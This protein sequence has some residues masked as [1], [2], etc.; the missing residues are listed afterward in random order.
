MS[1][2]EPAKILCVDDEVKV[3]SGLERTLF[4]HFD[5]HTANSGRAALERMS[6][7]GPFSVIVSDMRMPEMDGAAFLAEAKKRAPDSVRILLTGH[8]D[9]QAAIDAVN[10]GSIYRFLSKPCEPTVLIDTLQQAVKQHRLAS[11]EK[12]LLANTLAAAVKSMVRLLEMV[13]PTAFRK[14]TAM[15]DY[16]HHVC[17]ILKLED[18][19]MYET[20]ALL[21][22]AGHIVLP[23]S[24]LDKADAR[25]ELTAQEKEMVSQAFATAA[26]LAREIPRLEPVGEIISALGQPAKK[27]RSLDERVTLGVRLLDAADRLDVLLRSGVALSQ[28]V[29]E[30]RNLPQE[31]RDALLTFKPSHAEATTH[32]LRIGSLRAGMI[33]DQDVVAK[34]G[35]AVARKGHE[36][37]APMVQRLSNFDKSVGIEQP[38]RVVVPP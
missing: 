29:S 14:A 19:W 1:E 31:M 9:M 22:Q 17:Q 7:D 12:E 20:A 8:A 38:I 6:E 5:V 34:G 27:R 16:V 21:S 25:Q 3:L 33:L 13:A 28:A 4:E 32:F 10:H 18:A 35:M 15:N 26:N 30:L 37:T 11:L 23:T 24:T 36:L 2:V